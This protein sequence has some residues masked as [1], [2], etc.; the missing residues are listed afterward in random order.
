MLVLAME[1]SRCAQRAMRTPHI[2]EQTDEWVRM[3][4]GERPIGPSMARSASRRRAV[5]PRAVRWTGSEGRS[6]KTE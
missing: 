5:S 4:T 2:K 6:L 1:F 3:G